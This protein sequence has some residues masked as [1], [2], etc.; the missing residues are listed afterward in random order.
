MHRGRAA[1]AAT[2]NLSLFQTSFCPPKYIIS[3]R[4]ITLRNAETNRST[5]TFR[6]S[7]HGL[8]TST[9]THGKHRND[10]RIHRSFFTSS[11]DYGGQ[12][13]EPVPKIS[14]NK[15][16]GKSARNKSGSQNRTQRQNRENKNTREEKESVNE[17]LHNLNQDVSRT[18]RV[19][20]DQVV[21]IFSKIQ[22]NGGC[23]SNEALL[24]LR[25]CGNLIVDETPAKRSEMSEKLWAYYK[26]KGVQMDVSHYNTLLKNH[27]D[28]GMPELHP[29]EFLTM[30]EENGIEA[31]RVTFQHLIAK[32][33]SDGDIQGATTILEHMK[34][35]KI[36]VNENVF[37]SLMIGHSRAGDIVEAKSLMEVMVES[38]L[39][40]S[41]ETKMIYITELARAGESFK[42][43]LEKAVGEGEKFTDQEYLK[44][45][46]LLSEKGEKAAAHEIVE[47][48]PKNR[49]FFQEMRNFI[50]TMIASGELELPYRIFEGFSPSKPAQEAGEVEKD[51][52]ES[53]GRFFLQAM[54]K[55]EYDP[56][57]LMNYLE[58]IEG[59][60][61]NANICCRLLEHCADLENTN[62]GQ[63]VYDEIVSRY[64]KDVELF[65]TDN[66]II[67]RVGRL[68]VQNMLDAPENTS[69]SIVQLLIKMGAIGLSI[70]AQQLSEII[71]PNALSGTNTSPEELFSL[72]CEVLK[73]QDSFGIH[74]RN[75][76]PPNLILNCLVRYLLFRESNDHFENAAKLCFRYKTISRPSFWNIALARSYLRTES[77]NPIITILGLSSSSFK[78]VDESSQD[79]EEEMVKKDSDVFQT[80]NHILDS[81]PR[82]HSDKKPKELLLPVLKA[83]SE[84][85]LGIPTNVIET[86]KSN[87]KNDADELNGLLSQLQDNYK[88]RKDIWTQEVI[89]EFQ[90]N[91][92][93]IHNFKFNIDRSDSFTP[94]SSNAFIKPEKLPTNLKG[95]EEVQ[96]I[97]DKKNL[98]NS[99]VTNKLLQIYIE[100]GKLDD[101][102]G[103]IKKILERGPIKIYPDTFDKYINACTKNNEFS[104]VFKF[105]ELLPSFEQSLVFM[106]TYV[107]LSISLAKQGEHSK[108]IE[109]FESVDA[110]IFGND[111]KANSF[112]ATKIPNYYASIGDTENYGKILDVLRKAT[113]ITSN[114]GLLD[115]ETYL[116]WSSSES[117][118]NDVIEQFE[119]IVKEKKQLPSYGSTLKLLKDL[120]EIQDTN[121]I[122]RII[123]ASSEIIGE[124][125]SYYNLAFAFLENKKLPQAKKI[126]STP[127][128]QYNEKKVSYYMNRLSLKQGLEELEDLV[129]VCR[130]LSGCDR[131]SMYSFL[132]SECHKQNEVERIE[133]IWVNMQ[134]EGFVP[135]EEIKVKM[136]DALNSKGINVPFE[137]PE[138]LGNS[139]TEPELLKDNERVKPPNEDHIKDKRETNEQKLDETLHNALTN[140]DSNGV[141]N[142][143][144]Y[145]SENGNKDKTTDGAVVRF[146]MD[147]KDTDKKADILQTILNDK[148]FKSLG[149]Y[150]NGFLR[151]VVAILTKSQLQNILRNVSSPADHKL[152]RTIENK[153]CQHLV[154]EDLEGFMNS[155]EANNE[156][157][158]F[159]PSQQILSKVIQGDLNNMERL[160]KIAEQRI[161]TQ[162]KFAG[163]T[164]KATFTADQPIEISTRLWNML[165]KGELLNKDQLLDIQQLPKTPKNIKDD[166]CDVLKTLQIK[167]KD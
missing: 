56:K 89:Q 158:F 78:K 127:G 151:F 98:N 74:P 112:R 67:Q 115:I 100:E 59:P 28:N 27:L 132:I 81:S 5:D 139:T 53:H 140:G 32:Y 43:E 107:D 33:C 42:Q 105:L 96:A 125:A 83:L 25:C 48:L 117:N 40:V 146:I 122:Q 16:Q 7:T 76:I 39:D 109:L 143:Y 1:I 128:M 46:V 156:E 10:F 69:N 90:N 65:A 167:K 106:T 68:R 88:N 162:P 99:L 34:E 57:V 85:K 160:M 124:E 154:T 58:K 148:V 60:S 120:I 44:L 84:C 137:V 152:Y 114:T 155:L 91:R 2:R 51:V 18:G 75:P 38:G 166:V 63:S 47:K 64:L 30:M 130:S 13:Q 113:I 36:P 9:D 61:P 45:I 121:G 80:L 93:K 159:V 52:P 77:L 131:Q 123:D 6:I 17:A 79:A 103:Y 41:S 147:L 111:K 95:L 4:S 20:L 110:N 94:I 12:Q 92:R 129:L 70:R 153:L 116:H 82:Y 144:K 165:K 141:L 101:A 54:I 29:S 119:T 71:I 136:A 149:S 108:I 134:E 163:N 24:L 55:N 62:Y 142:R 72:Y 22:Q 164:L 145:L 126:F 73:E 87:L 31:N 86:L 161:A 35:H 15:V 102:D 135:S 26:D 118:M 50:P 21:S 157:I 14:S 138:L 97:L 150:N 19:Y 3:S 104:R 37:H 11:L 23:S 133:D 66:F 8:T 49:G